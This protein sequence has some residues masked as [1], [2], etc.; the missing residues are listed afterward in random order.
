LRRGLAALF[1]GVGLV[2]GPLLFFRLGAALRETRTREAA[3]PRTGRYVRAGDV[4]LFVQ[5]GGPR[6]GPA[7]VFLHGTGSWGELWR[8]T[9]DATAAAGFRTLA[10]DLPP[11]GYSER[12]VAGAYRTEDQ[13]RRIVALMESLDLRQVTLVGHSFGGRATLLAAMQ[14]R[15]RMQALVLVDPA[16]GLDQPAEDGAGVLTR[17]LLAARPLR[18]ALVASVVTNPLFTRKLLSTMIAD[19][20][21]ATDARV[22][23][24]QAPLV[25][26]GST[27]AVGEWARVFLTAS[28]AVL[29][30]E[31]AARP[32]APPVLLVWG[33]QDTLTPL[34][35]GHRLAARIPG[36]RLV[37][38]DGLG[39]IPQIESPGRFNQALLEFLVARP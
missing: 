24:L 10:L 6:E 8:E 20:A 35:Q 25:I 2:V 33:S 11:F 7:L 32:P 37:V 21:A 5:E 13:A 15:E 3:A 22:A 39:H 18:N 19:P 31:L 30:S 12:P 34:D 16:L 23:V 1:L 28:D 14:A 36:S 17:G 29:R 26:E 27:D 4:A 38:L 9:L